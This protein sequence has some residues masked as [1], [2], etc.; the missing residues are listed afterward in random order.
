MT[1]VMSLNRFLFYLDKQ[2]TISRYCPWNNGGSYQFTSI[3]CLNLT[4]IQFII[5][6]EEQLGRHLELG[7][8]LTGVPGHSQH[9]VVILPPQLPAHVEQSRIKHFLNNEK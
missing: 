8:L 2:K 4:R 7:F 1:L 5:F 9:F 3:I 6:K